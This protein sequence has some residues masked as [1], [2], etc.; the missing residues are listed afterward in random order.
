MKGRRW[1]DAPI[2][3]RPSTFYGCV[4]VAGTSVVRLATVHGPEAPLGHV[5]PLP[6][7]EGGRSVAANG[8]SSVS[9][10][11][12]GSGLSV[13]LIL[14]AP[15]ESFAFVS[16]AFVSCAPLKSAPISN[17]P[18]KVGE[19]PRAAVMVVSLNVAETR[20]AP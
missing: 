15:V 18:A 1:I 12:F 13:T 16:T 9:G 10:S 11:S 17:A 14:P 7:I 5:V 4:H 3:R 20:H 8:S 6:V 2:P 19:R